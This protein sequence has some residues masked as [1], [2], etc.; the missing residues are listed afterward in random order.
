MIHDLLPQREHARQTDRVVQWRH[1]AK[2]VEN[3]SL[4]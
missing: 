3:A 4:P 2:V 1:I